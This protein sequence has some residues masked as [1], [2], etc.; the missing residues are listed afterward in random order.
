MSPEL[1]KH[2]AY[3]YEVDWWAMGVTVYFMLTGEVPWDGTQEM[4]E[5]SIVNERVTFDPLDEVDPVAQDFVQR[6]R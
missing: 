1:I 6:V 4:V 3:S 2:E 5:R